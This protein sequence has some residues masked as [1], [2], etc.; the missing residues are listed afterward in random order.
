MIK[1]ARL[2]SVNS[3]DIATGFEMGEVQIESSGEI[4]LAFLSPHIMQAGEHVALIPKG[5]E[6]DPSI[7]RLL[8]AHPDLLENG[9]LK[10][11]FAIKIKEIYP[12]LTF[13]CPK[14]GNFISVIKDLDYD[15]SNA[16]CK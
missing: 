3:E 8:K 2:Y 6:I 15:Y 10:R 11:S 1:K 9:C 14:S 13:T 4:V 16:W 5:K 7:L 12:S